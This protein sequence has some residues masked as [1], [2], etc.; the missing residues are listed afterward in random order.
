[1]SV[2]E[3]KKCRRS[4]FFL[5]GVC[6]PRSL[7]H[8][9]CRRA[10]VQ[11]GIIGWFLFFLLSSCREKDRTSALPPCRVAR[12]SL[13]LF[14][15]NGLEGLRLLKRSKRKNSLHFYFHALRSTIIIECLSEKGTLAMPSR[16]KQEDQTCRTNAGEQQQ[17]VGRMVLRVDV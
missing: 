16:H 17:E 6:G 4:D 15:F 8:R 1:V 11:D 14:V 13:L 7:S 9:A 12:H 5:P 3:K 10:R 2:G